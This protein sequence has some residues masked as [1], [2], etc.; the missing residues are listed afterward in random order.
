MKPGWYAVCVDYQAGPFNTEEYAASVARGFDEGPCPND[1]WTAREDEAQTL[2]DSYATRMVA[3]MEEG[4][5][6]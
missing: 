2:A 4:S 3:D 1:H 6:A 5:D